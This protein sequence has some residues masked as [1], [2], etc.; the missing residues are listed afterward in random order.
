MSNPV[1]GIDIDV[2]LNQHELKNFSLEPFYGRPANLFE[3]RV[4]HNTE[5][6]CVEAFSNGYVVSLCNTPAPSGGGSSS[7]TTVTTTSYSMVST[8]YFII[9]D[10]DTAGSLMTINLL[11]AVTVGDGYEV[12]IKKR[13]STATV[14]VDGNGAQTIDDSLTISI[15]IQYESVTLISDGTQWFIK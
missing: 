14:V 8:D 2:D 1:K 13:G 5:T 12:T 6:G 10:D 4:W 9:A 7:T 15:T 11:S 3:G